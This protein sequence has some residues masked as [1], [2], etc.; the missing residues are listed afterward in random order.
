MG[1]YKCGRNLELDQLVASLHKP[2]LTF[3]NLSAELAAKSDNCA[4][5][6]INCVVCFEHKRQRSRMV[7]RTGRPS[8]RVPVLSQLLSHQRP[9]A[10][11]PKTAFLR[12]SGFHMGIA[13]LACIAGAFERTLQRHFQK[14]WVSRRL[15]CWRTLDLSM[16]VGSGSAGCSDNPAAMDR[17]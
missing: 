6:D 17:F 14:G 15:A 11:D 1:S 9:Q 3:P 16:P 2:A 8:S 7:W 4:L 12:C 5:N 13:E 10:P